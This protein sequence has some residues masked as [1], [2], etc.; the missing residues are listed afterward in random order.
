M[1]IIWRIFNDVHCASKQLAVLAFTCIQKF[2]SDAQKAK[3]I[4][5]GSTLFGE[6]R[7][8]SCHSINGKGDMLRR[9]W[10]KSPAKECTV[11]LQLYQGAEVFMP[12]VPMPRYRFTEDDLASVVAYMQSEFVDYDM[13]QLPPHTP[14]GFL[15]KGLAILRKIIVPDV[16]NFKP[17]P[18]LRNWA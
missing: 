17:L 9:S 12:D 3:L 2:S 13:Q 15:R 16:I 5:K 11:A 7:C 10:V 1:R 8:I 14:T 4:D 6:A 18:A